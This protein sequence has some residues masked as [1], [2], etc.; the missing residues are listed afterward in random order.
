MKRSRAVTK[1]ETMRKGKN[2]DVLR[3]EIEMGRVNE[4]NAKEKK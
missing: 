2:D 3:E 4:I 1:R